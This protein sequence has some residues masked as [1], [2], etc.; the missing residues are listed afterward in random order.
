M[1]THAEAVLPAAHP[2]SLSETG[3]RFILYGVSWATYERLLADFADSHAAHFAYDQGALEIMAPSFQHEEINRLIATLFEVIAAEMDIDCVNAGST[4][5]KRVDLARG[6]E[7]DTCFYMRNNAACVRGKEEIDLAVDPPPDLVIE[8]DITS[9]S[10]NKLPIYAAVGVPEVWRYDRQRVAIF[11][12][13]GEVYN[14]REE[15]MVLPR[16][17]GA[18]ISSF[19]AESKT[20]QRPA[21]LRKLREWGRKQD[22]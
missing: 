6:F 12:L 10:L 7:P 3:P 16:L 11:T 5:F 22:A 21:W 15:S 18:V 8:I 1:N 19:L 20:L 9:P 4:T 14:E 13:A 17:T 2:A